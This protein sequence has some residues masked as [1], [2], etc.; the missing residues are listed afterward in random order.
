MYSQIGEII[1]K[2][3]ANAV[4]GGQT[5]EAALAA[6]QKQAQQELGPQVGA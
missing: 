2:A 1:I 3:M 4:S 5:V 6:A